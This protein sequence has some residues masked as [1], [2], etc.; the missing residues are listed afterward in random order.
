MGNALILKNAPRERIK[1][2]LLSWPGS[3]LDWSNEDLNDFASCFKSY[4]V[5]AGKEIS[6]KDPVSFFIVATGS[7]EIQAIVP[8]ICKKTRNIREFLCKK[9]K[10]DM[11]FIPSMRKLIRVSNAKEFLDKENKRHSAHRDHKN[12]LDLIDTLCIKSINASTI[13]QLDWKKFD[14]YFINIE[15]PRS[16]RIDV[17]V[18]RTMMETNLTDY[19]EKLPILENIPYS[20]LETLVRMCHYNIEKEGKVI[21]R[22]GDL[23]KEVYVI[24]SGEVKVEAMASQRT[25]ELLSDKDSAVSSPPAKG[26]NNCPYSA[27]SQEQLTQRRRT[28]LEAR[29]ITTR[30][31]AKNRLSRSP[32]SDNEKSSPPLAFEDENSDSIFVELA[33][34]GQGD[35][36]GEMATFI[37]L[38]RAATVTVTS[39][40]VLM[41]SLSKTDFRTLY[42]A[43]S[44]D[45]APSIER[46][47]KNHMLQ[48]IFQLKSPFLEQI[49]SDQ[50]DKMA[51]QATIEKLRE[52]HV[53]FNQGENADKF[54]F[55]YSGSLKVQKSKKGGNMYEVERLY[56]GYYFGEHAVINNS[57]RLA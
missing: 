18:L 48:N 6:T 11:V 15:R 19:L 40:S 9:D 53:V 36:F 42:H 35:Y 8:T 57:K 41:T 54:Y 51:E 44:P 34:L 14:D 5:A 21:C 32:T 12:V 29:N 13:L 31:L 56:L 3:I 25:A 39:K 26:G 49:G 4:H 33:R 43:I 24:L 17:N 50:I 16:S 38:P 37:D 20:K 45:L 30:E 46:M 23:G 22:E 10:G 27:S 28:L 1:K 2:H 47:V 55:V 7:V 52:G